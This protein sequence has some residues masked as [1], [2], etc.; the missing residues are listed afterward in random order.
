MQIEELINSGFANRVLIEALYAKYQIDPWSLDQKWREVFD[1]LEIV[2]PTHNTSDAPDLKIKRLI[3]AYRTF[4][5]LFASVNPIAIAELTEP[6]QLKLETLGFCEE[7]LSKN[8]PTQGFLSKE[9]AP[10]QEIVS[11]LQT[12][13]CG[14]IGIEYKGVQNPDIKEWL[15]SQVEPNRLKAPL[16]IE[17]KKIILQHLNKSE[18]FE[19]FL[20]TKYV[21]QKRFSLE[22]CESLIPIISAL[23]ETGSDLGL[24]EFYIGMA[25]R[26][27]L[28]LLSNIMQK[29]YAQIFSEF[30]E[31]Y[32]PASFEGSGD[33]KYHKGFYSTLTTTNGHRVNIALTPNPSH[34]ESVYPVVEGQVRALQ[35]VQEDLQKEHSVPLIIHGDAAVSGQ[36]VVYETMQMIDLKGY[37]TGGSIHIVINNQVGFTTLPKDSRSTHYCTDIA[38][39]FDVPI[40]HVNAE[41]PEACVYVANLAIEMRQKFHID[42]FI[43]LLCYR[44][45]GHNESDEPAFTQ[46]LEYQLIRTK[47]P[48][49]EIYRDHLIQQGVLERQMAQALEEEFKAS[50]QEARSGTQGLEIEKNGP[51]PFQN[52]KESSLF[53]AVETGVSI[54]RLKEIGCALSRIPEG[55]VIHKKLERLVAERLEMSEGRKSLDWGM[56]EAFAF[57]TL[58]WEG[59]SVRISGQDSCRGTFSH[60]HALWVD[61]EKEKGYFPLKHLCEGQGLFDV[62]N[63]PLSEFAVL[64]F[65]F[66]YSIAGSKTLVIWEAQFGDFCNGAQV[67]IDQYISTSEMKWGQKSNLVLLLPHG[68]EGQGPEHSSA[69]MERFLMLCGNQNMI[70]ANPSLPVQFYHLLRRQIVKPCLK[71]LIVFTPKG[72]LRHPE[73]V[74]DLN[75]FAKGSFQEILDDPEKP[76]NVEK[77]VFC[78]GR[79]YY[80]IIA[81]RRLRN[82]QNMA[83]VRI[84]QLYPFHFDQVE[85]IVEKYVGFKECFWVQEEP[86]NM[87]AWYFMRPMLKPLLQPVYIGRPRSASPAVGSFALHKKEH[88]EIMDSLFG[89]KIKG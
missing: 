55:F 44:K 42:V 52:N 13:Y 33:V 66:G 50:L 89:V 48:I 53:Q 73:C 45:Y 49:R 81:E 63:S 18:L 32:I 25:H 15:Q 67:V 19:V 24:R 12:T 76:V 86:E 30:E 21:G 6:S 68:Y 59:T 1:Q 39:A 78:S 88:A 10:L 4:G 83:V 14:N 57:A 62:F 75:D 26:G 80:D 82:V 28:N 43:D 79:I 11:S 36:G 23:I 54:E 65:E 3:N 74:S 7:D 69:R 35:T 47:K 60:R 46:P 2:Y 58:L 17:Q 85:K 20:H 29:S 22:G 56:G 27:R 8:Y 31:G 84:E 9:S 38:K 87:G 34:L 71:P 72:L 77:L 61:Q 51:C 70:V 5:H 40:F 37:C 64:G 41:D 16:N